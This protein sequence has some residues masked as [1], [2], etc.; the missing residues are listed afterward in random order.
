MKRYTM[1]AVF[2]NPQSLESP[3]SFRHVLR[4][5]TKRVG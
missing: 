4:G 2:I 5:P 3:G 1:L